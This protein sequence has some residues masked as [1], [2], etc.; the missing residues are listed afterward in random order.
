MS[1]S[2]DVNVVN[3]FLTSV[4]EVI[5]TMAQI[6][7]TPQKPYVKDDSAAQ[8]DVTGIIGITGQDRGTISVTF[9]EECALQ[10]TSNML[11]EP[12]TSLGADVRDAVGE[13]TN[14]IS[15]QAR[16][17]LAEIGRKYHAAIPSVVMGTNHTI[18]HVA[19][20]PILAIPFDSPFGAITVEV[21]FA[22]VTE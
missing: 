1:G 5:G 10:V 11:G 19:D 4:V 14:M 3:P 21:C 2:L 6:K 20:G 8:G 7:V 22:A 13:L 12:I 9:K 15:G 17:G 16:R 18:K